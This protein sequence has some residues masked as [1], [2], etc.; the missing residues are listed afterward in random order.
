LPLFGPI[1]LQRTVD[2][3]VILLISI[4]VHELAHAV[5][6][7]RLGDPTPRR[8]GEI[9]LNPFVHMDQFGI[10]LLLLTSI[11]QWGFTYGRTHVTPTNLKFGPQRGNAIV[12]IAGPLSNLVLA[13]IAAGVL[14]LVGNGILTISDNVREFLVLAMFLNILLLVINLFPIPPLDGFTVLGGFLTARQMY[15]LAPLQQWGPIIFLVVFV[16]NPGGISGAILNPPLEHIANFLCST[17]C[18]RGAIPTG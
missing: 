16:V 4:D 17:S 15:A 13:A 11:A 18:V 9:S 5:V 12:A 1:D 10:I 7:D 14:T 6:A 8:L 2:M 3:I